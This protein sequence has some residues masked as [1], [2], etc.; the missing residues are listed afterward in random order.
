MTLGSQLKN[1]SGLIKTIL[2]IV[3][4]SN[5]LVVALPLLLTAMINISNISNLSFA[6]FFAAGGIVFLA[7]SMAIVIGLLGWF[8]LSGGSKR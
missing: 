1:P 5:V 3:L 4:A 7:I 8:G 6:S 2:L